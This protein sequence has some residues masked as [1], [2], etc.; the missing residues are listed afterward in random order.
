MTMGRGSYH[1]FTQVRANL[2][3]M[4]KASGGTKDKLMPT[5]YRVIADEFQE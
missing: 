3:A 5:E 2:I 4:K 1:G